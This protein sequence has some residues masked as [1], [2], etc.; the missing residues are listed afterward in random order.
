VNLKGLTSA[1]TTS[2]CGDFLVKGLNLA[3]T[4]VGSG[5]PDF[6]EMK[7]HDNS[8]SFYHAFSSVILVESSRLGCWRFSVDSS[9]VVARLVV[10][11]DAVINHQVGEDLANL[12][13]DNFR[14]CNHSWRVPFVINQLNSP[15]PFP[16][17]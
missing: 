12:V 17:L 11:D 7:A 5:V 2:L 15:F 10:L 16:T 9:E 4:R 8:A 1:F 3:P 14:H 6:A 13:C